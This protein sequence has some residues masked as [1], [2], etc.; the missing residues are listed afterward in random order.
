MTAPTVT[1]PDEVRLI[2]AEFMRQVYLAERT[3]M[4]RMAGLLPIPDKDP[5]GE[6]LIARVEGDRRTRR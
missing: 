5:L 3:K 2:N 6:R 4:A 1:D